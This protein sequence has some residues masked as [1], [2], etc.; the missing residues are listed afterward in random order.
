MKINQPRKFKKNE[1]NQCS[2]IKNIK[3]QTDILETKIGSFNPTNPGKL[4]IKLLRSNKCCCANEIDWKFSRCFKDI[5]IDRLHTKQVSF[6]NIEQ[7]KC[8]LLMRA[9]CEHQRDER[10]RAQLEFSSSQNIVCLFVRFASLL[11]RKE[12]S[13]VSCLDQS[14]CIS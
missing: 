8:E 2:N 10:L 13:F 14:L 9:C 7:D 1:R 11:R 12:G 3:A 4:N 5:E 6:W